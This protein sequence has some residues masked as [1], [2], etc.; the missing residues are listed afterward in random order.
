[1]NNYNEN[2]VER[3]I[4]LMELHRYQEA[5][6]EILSAIQQNG[7][8][9]VLHY[10]LW[11]ECLF[12][13]NRIGEAKALLKEALAEYPAAPNLL[14]YLALCYQ[15]EEALGKAHTIIDEAIRLRPTNTW[16]LA[17]KANLFCQALKY[18][19]ALKIVD[20]ALVLDPEYGRLFFIKSLA[21]YG[22]NEPEAALDHLQR[23]LKLEPNE[24]EYIALHARLLSELKQTEQAEAHAK[25]ALSIDPTNQ[26]AK[27]TLLEIYKNKNGLFRFF[28]GHGF[29]R[30]QMEWTVWRVLLAIL[31]W[32]GVMLWGG[33][34]L[35][36]L[37]VTWYGSVLYNSIMRLHTTYYLLLSEEDR[38][39]SNYFLGANAVL[40]VTTLGFLF[41][42]HLLASSSW[43]NLM[44]GSILFLFI[45]ISYFEIISNLG[46]YFVVAFSLFSAALLVTFWTTGT[47]LFMGPLLLIL[48]A[49]LFT[50]RVFY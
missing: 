44:V 22:Q 13:L 21:Y 19:K 24:E 49:F 6:K 35:I 9:A 46:R 33:L 40:I 10:E 25:A 27:N 18:D 11:G 30:Y 38:Q 41:D 37:L 31:F 12:S 20:E 5:I 14:A 28:V 4:Q 45:G 17:I 15:K 39:Q 3:A 16:L 32:K 26:L 50:F 8:P 43:V 36:Y 2:Y 48:Y 34:F 42:E 47:F 7:N 23:A 1:M 29:G